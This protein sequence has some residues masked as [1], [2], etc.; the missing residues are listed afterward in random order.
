MTEPLI[1]LPFVIISGVDEVLGCEELW[2]I[3]GVT[4]FFVY[5]LNSTGTLQEFNTSVKKL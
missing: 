2:G 1:Q 3:L 4:S 5:V